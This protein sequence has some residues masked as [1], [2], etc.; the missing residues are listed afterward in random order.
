MWIFELTNVIGIIYYDIYLPRSCLFSLFGH[1]TWLWISELPKKHLIYYCGHLTWKTYINNGS[2]I[3]YVI[4]VTSV[5]VIMK[6][7][8][9][10]SSQN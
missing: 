8:Q 1:L 10:I 9:L 2:I 6:F 7:T 5:T 4:L 3:N